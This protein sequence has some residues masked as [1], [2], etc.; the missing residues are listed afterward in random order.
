MCPDKVMLKK[1]VNQISDLPS[2]PPVIPRLLTTLEEP[3][4][5]AEDVEQIL[6]NDPGL[7]ARLLKLVNSAY[8]GL[9]RKI[10]SVKD[11]VV[12]LGF[13]TVRNLAVGASVIHIS[14]K[15]AKGKSDER[16][17]FDMVGLWKKA[18]GTGVG[19]ETTAH[20]I[21]YPKPDDA[22]IAG[23]LHVLGTVILQLYFPGE[24]KDILTHTQENECS[25]L[26]AEKE[27][28]GVKD[29]SLSGWLGENWDLPPEIVTGFSNYHHPL[30][31]DS[32]ETL[33]PALVYIGEKL[34]RANGLGW[35]GDEIRSFPDSQILGKMGFT[36]TE[37]EELLEEFN[38]ALEEATEFLEMAEEIEAE[39]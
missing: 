33:L 25:L 11:A 8:Y 26:E 38:R 39:E 2:L 5:T 24:M 36:K 21:R 32:E 27:I 15:K 13:N 3:D 6:L 19:A 35:T 9:N 34:V 1:L 22:F 7:T 12:Y 14:A 23:L 29:P 16:L 10:E 31:I 4:T 37:F 18:I 28:L 17:E 30:K 20:K